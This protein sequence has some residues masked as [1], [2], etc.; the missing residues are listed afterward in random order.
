MEQQTGGQLVQLSDDIH[1][2]GYAGRAPRN[3]RPLVVEGDS[4]VP[5]LRPGD[6]VL[7]DYQCTRVRGDGLYI[8]RMSEA[9]L[10]KQLQP[11]LA[12][13]GVRVTAWNKAYEPFTVPAEQLDIIGR[14]VWTCRH[15]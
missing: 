15:V 3:L 11:L 6:I 5:G 8:I 4:M 2:D 1:R 7:V 14:V 12:S 9:I 13:D 10:I